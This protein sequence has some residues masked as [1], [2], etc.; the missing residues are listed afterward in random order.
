M[1]CPQRMQ[2]GVDS[3]ACAGMKY[4]ETCVVDCIKGWK[5]VG[6]P[7]V[8]TCA[9]KTTT[10]LDVSCQASQCSSPPQQDAI[11]VHDCAGKKNGQ[12][13]TLGCNPTS[14][15][16]VGITYT[17]NANG[18]F[19][20]SGTPVCKELSVG[21]DRAFLTGTIVMVANG[22]TA[23][24]IGAATKKALATSLGA[25]ETGFEVAVTESRRLDG[26]LPQARRLAGTWTAAYTFTFAA[27]DL[28]IMQARANTMTENNLFAGYMKTELVAAGAD[29]STLGFGV[30]SITATLAL[31]S[32]STTAVKMDQESSLAIS[33]SAINRGAV[34]ALGCALLVAL[35]RQQL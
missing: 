21:N 20:G 32:P 4:G 13:C 7:K 14:H 18:L 8:W 26:L 3:S 1:V 24:Q 23:V 34:L 22:V 11:I 16:G 2:A 29:E 31:G 9:G 6:V 35:A 19:S 25:Q 15:V 10:G 27:T 28:A 12:T 5:N 30:T 17:C 33:N